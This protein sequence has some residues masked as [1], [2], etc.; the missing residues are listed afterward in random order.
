MDTIIEEKSEEFLKE[1]L[2]ALMASAM[3][4]LDEQDGEE[5]RLELMEELVD[6]E[7]INEI[8]EV[9]SGELETQLPTPPRASSIFST[10]L[11]AGA[12]NVVFGVVEKETRD[13]NVVV[14]L[15]WVFNSNQWTGYDLLDALGG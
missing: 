15:I 13:C 1:K 12:S 11:E 2:E 14:V 6:E 3:E 8:E 5:E 4:F 9:G 10:W 7:R